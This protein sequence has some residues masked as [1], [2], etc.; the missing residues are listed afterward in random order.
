LR[1]GQ[2]RWIAGITQPL[3]DDYEQSLLVVYIAWVGIVAALYI[4]C[5]WFAN[6][7]RQRRQ[8][9]LSYL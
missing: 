4:P 5:R 9:W 7:K 8:W 1:Y 6:V 2:G 3:P